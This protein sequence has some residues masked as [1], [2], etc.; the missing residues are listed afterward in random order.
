MGT[1]L[2]GRRFENHPLS[3]HGRTD[4]DGVYRNVIGGPIAAAGMPIRNTS[5]VIVSARRRA[6]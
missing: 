3:L 2:I 1:K 4:S 6:Q 5:D